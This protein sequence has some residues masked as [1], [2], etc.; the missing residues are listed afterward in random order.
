MSNIPSLVENCLDLGRL[1]FLPVFT[2]ATIAWLDQQI[3]PDSKYILLL[4][5]T[6]TIS[7]KLGLSVMSCCILIPYLL[8]SYTRS[9]CFPPSYQPGLLYRNLRH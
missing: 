3:S 2:C 8:D 5:L 1:Y 9:L 7:K 4:E 6:T